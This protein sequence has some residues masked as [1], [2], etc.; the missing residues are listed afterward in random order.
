MVRTWKKEGSLPS[1]CVDILWAPFGE[2]RLY[3]HYFPFVYFSPKGGL[4]SK[5]VCCDWGCSVCFLRELYYFPTWPYSTIATRLL[6]ILK[7]KV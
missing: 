2:A 7:E 4:S 3:T 5:V 1:Y 6:R